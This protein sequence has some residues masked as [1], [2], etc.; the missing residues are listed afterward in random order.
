MCSYPTAP[1]SDFALS[2]QVLDRPC[3][4]LNRHSRIDTV[5]E[6]QIDH[7]NPQALERRLGSDSRGS[8]PDRPPRLRHLDAVATYGLRAA[9][10]V[11]MRLED[12]DWR[13]DVLGVRHAKTGTYSELPLTVSART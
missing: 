6:E 8:L 10:I 9:E 13:R 5:L 7:V 3:D 2:D 4:V 1:V 12:V 11:R